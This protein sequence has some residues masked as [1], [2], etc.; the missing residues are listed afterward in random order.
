MTAGLSQTIR[1]SQMNWFFGKT[2]TAPTN[3]FVSLHS[4]DPGDTGANE[5]SATGGYARLNYGINTNWNNASGSGDAAST[6]TNANAIVFTSTGAFSA[7][8]TYLGLWS[9]SSGG[10]FYGRAAVT[11]TQTITGSGQSVN[12]PIGSA[13]FTLVVT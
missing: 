9:A 8:V 4:A 1:Q 2:V 5:L 10:T 12:I 13:S 7:A 11:P 3:I 6:S